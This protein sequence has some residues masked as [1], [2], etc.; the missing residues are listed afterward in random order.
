MDP[1]AVTVKDLSRANGDLLLAACRKSLRKLYGFEAGKP[2]RSSG[3]VNKPPRKWNIPAVVSTEMQKSLPQ[4]NH[5]SSLRRCDGALG[6]AC[7][8]TG[9]SGFVAAG[10]LVS[11][12]ANDQFIIPRKF[13]GNLPLTKT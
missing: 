2:F 3:K 6:T 12:I 4:G 11:M 1:C 7:F 13:K 10:Q 9:T 8:V 5:A